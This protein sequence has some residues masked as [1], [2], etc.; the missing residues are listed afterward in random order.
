MK[1]IAVI[2]GG[3][4]GLMAAGTAHENGAEV[5]LFERNAKLGRKIAITGKGRCNVTNNCSNEEFLKNVVTNPR[6]LYSALSGFSAEDTMSFFEQRHVPLKTERGRR[7]FPVSDKAYDIVDALGAYASRCRIIYKR[8]TGVAK[9][10]GNVS[11]V[12]AD[13]DFY[14]FDAVI[15]CTGGMSYPLTGSDGDGYRFAA[16]LGHTVNELRPALTSLDSDDSFCRELA[17]LSL[18]NVTLDVTRGKKKIYSELGEMLFTHTGISGPLVLTASSYMKLS[19][20]SDYNVTVD[21]KPALDNDMLDRR[22]L[23]D[24]DKYSHKDF[25]NALGDLL[26][27]KLIPIITEMSG[28]ELRKKV[29]DITRAERMELCRLI[30]AFPIS[31]KGFRPISE[32]VVTAGGVSVKEIDPSTM[33]S[34]LVKGLYF[35]GE[36]IDVDA[37]TGGYNL[38][39][40]FSTGRRAG[41]SASGI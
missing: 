9:E 35:A 19:P 7:V 29:Y 18:K 4:A 36:V 38:Q 17:G 6:F 2:G 22:I 28:I 31:I 20:I 15:I 21:L 33:E 25:V 26:P 23:S 37:L 40:A 30:K 41:L 32:A 34:K 39:I 1:K 24:F 12:Y 10:D 16:S 5:T 3:A 13:G 14:P 27:L 11:G 8:V